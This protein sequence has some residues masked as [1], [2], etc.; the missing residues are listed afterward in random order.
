MNEFQ[1]RLDEIWRSSRW[2]SNITSAA[3]DRQFNRGHS[4]PLMSI[5]GRPAS[6]ATTFSDI[7][8]PGM[9]SLKPNGI[10]SS[11]VAGSTVPFQNGSLSRRSTRNSNNLR[12]RTTNNIIVPPSAEDNNFSSSPTLNNNNQL[13]NQ[14]ETDRP[15]IDRSPGDFF[16]FTKRTTPPVLPA[17]CGRFSE[18][19]HRTA[20]C[21]SSPVSSRSL[22]HQPTSSL[23]GT[24]SPRLG[25]LS[26]AGGCSSSV[27]R[28]FVAFECG[29]KSGISL[30]LKV[31]PSTTAGPVLLIHLTNFF[32]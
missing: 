15:T 2:I 13:E 6:P 11:A 5:L 24:P 20:S 16:K 27:I 3:R 21:S 31:V 26:L 30:R 22:S 10:I 9:S 32:V 14:S 1:Q 7:G 25:A 18:R 29:L 12:I 19:E 28:V 4:V 23:P 17:A 8:G